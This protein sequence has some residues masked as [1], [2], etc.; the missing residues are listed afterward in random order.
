MDWILTKYVHANNTALLFEI[1]M[2]TAEGERGSY[3]LY[4]N[5]LVSTCS[6]L[7]TESW[8]Y[9][10]WRREVHQRAE[11]SGFIAIW[12]TAVCLWGLKSLN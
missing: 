10:V 2:L 3:W 1:R 12:G 4:L 11:A 7:N 9:K 5:P 8:G 6:N